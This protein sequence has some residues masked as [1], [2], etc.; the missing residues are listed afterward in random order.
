MLRSSADT[1]SNFTQVL[2]HHLHHDGTFAN[3]GCHAFD[4]SMT[5]VAR[6]EHAGDRTLEDEWIAIFFPAFGA[7]AIAGEKRPGQQIAAVIGRQHTAQPT[8]ARNSA[9]E[10]E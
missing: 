4:R 10:D 2:M 5:S 3:S 6:R 8:R 1:S 7:I 9:D